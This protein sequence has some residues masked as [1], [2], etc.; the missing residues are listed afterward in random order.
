MQGAPLELGYAWAEDASS[1]LFPLMRGNLPEA[2]AQAVPKH[3]HCGCT[4]FPLSASL[5]GAR[6]VALCKLEHI[7]CPWLCR[8]EGVTGEGFP[9]HKASPGESQAGAMSCV[10]PRLLPSAPC[11]KH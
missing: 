5:G 4:G 8:A 7:L 6:V 10:L 3:R 2:R 1:L 9:G 11:V